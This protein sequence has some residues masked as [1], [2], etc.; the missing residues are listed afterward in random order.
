MLV[1]GTNPDSGCID[2]KK[3]MVDVT[4]LKQ[5]P[6]KFSEGL[7]IEDYFE[8]SS[9][10]KRRLIIASSLLFFV[11]ICGGSQSAITLS[12]IGQS[13]AK[14]HERSKESWPF[15]VTKRNRWDRSNS[16]SGEVNADRAGEGEQNDEGRRMNASRENRINGRLYT[17]LWVIFTYNNSCFGVPEWGRHFF[18][19][20]YM[21][22]TFHLSFDI[23]S[24]TWNDK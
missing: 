12:G 19:K 21:G 11:G 7:G 24:T 22:L 2:T 18:T 15:R 9:L 16:I 3:W 6:E 4:V 13:P 10:Y 14:I 17:K 23:I 1:V 20:S 8:Q 5:D